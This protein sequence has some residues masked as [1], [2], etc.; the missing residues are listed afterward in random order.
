V[1]RNGRIRTVPEGRREGGYVMFMLAITMIVL[2]TAC[3]FAVDLGSF[4]ARASRIQRAADAAA[5]AGVVW[6]PG[7]FAHAQTDAIAVAN[8]NG[9]NSGI[10][11]AAVPGNPYQLKVTINDPKVP[12]FFSTIL[13]KSP[14]SI[15]R[16]A[17]AEF[18]PLVPLGS[19]DNRL[20]ND[21]PASYN[22]NLWASISAPY[23][24][25]INGDPFSTKCGIGGSG[26]NCARTN[27]Q[28]RTTGYKYAIDVPAS[29]VG[30]TLTV[31]VYDAGNY[32][33]SNYANVETA[34][35][36]TVNTSFELFDINPAPLDI[37]SD[38]S[39]ALSLNGDC[40]SSP[41]KFYIADN[42]SASTYENKWATLC[43]IAV[44]KAG[45]YHL[46][47]KS[48]SL[49]TVAGAAVADSGNGWN[50]FSLKAS[51][52]G[53]GV[54]P[55]LYG[56]GDLS[57]FNNLPGLTGNITATFYFAQIA[58]VYAGKTLT[59]N[60]YDPG[61]GASGNYYVNVL[62]PGGAATSCSYGV[63]GTTLTAASPCRIQTRNS[64]GNTYNGKWLEIDIDIPTTYTC[65]ADCWWKISYEFLGVTSGNSPNDR[66][67]WSAALSGNPIHLVQ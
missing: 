34:D 11:V 60:L 39:S 66:T 46:Q 42:T 50:Q 9:F 23:T 57:L 61:D 26:T 15:T 17:T 49:T 10:T 51:V 53:T 47:V 52:S 38:F 54:T 6:M 19:P 48:S 36:G 40:T 1:Y 22:A 12:R 44:T 64:S 58:Q 14:M 4:Y 59:V 3:A 43:T 33:R 27:A 13:T 21:P 35:N 67:V 62:K 20:G 63:S 45:T 24:D 25:L 30:R 55:A 28:Y 32:A 65:S 8:K 41:G 18:A 16:S 56:V 37:S 31:S 5:L 29:A 2:F 7:D